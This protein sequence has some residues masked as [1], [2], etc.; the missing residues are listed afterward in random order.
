MQMMVNR[1]IMSFLGRTHRP[2]ESVPARLFRV[3]NLN[4]EVLAMSQLRG[5]EGKEC[6]TCSWRYL[7]D[8]YSLDA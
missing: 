4:V 7:P 3:M 5:F 8:R 2:S 6:E 1:H